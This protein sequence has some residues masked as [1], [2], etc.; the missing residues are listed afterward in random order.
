M[1]PKCLILDDSRMI[2][3]IVRQMLETLDLPVEE[4]G[5][6]E[7]AL[8]LC[9]CEMP[10]MILVDW[11]LPGMSGVDFIRAVRRQPN[12]SRPRILL[13]STE[14]CPDAISDALSAGA[15]AYLPK[16]FERAALTRHVEAFGLI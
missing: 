11:N 12:G 8:E 5:D 7:A 9:A 4:A 15:E 2:R 3:A 6:A 14:R 13:S 10:A 16:P 1:P